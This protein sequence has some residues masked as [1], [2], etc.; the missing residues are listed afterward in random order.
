MQIFGP[1]TAHIKI[2]QI[3]YAIF[4]A[5]RQFL[6]KLCNTLQCHD[7]QLLWNFLTETVYAWDKKNPSMY[8]F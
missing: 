7:T 3:P 6:F 2:N 5:T 1:W 4:Q 8:N